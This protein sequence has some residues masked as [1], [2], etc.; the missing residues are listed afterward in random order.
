MKPS[1][2]QIR[3][4]EFQ[5][6]G[7]KRAAALEL[8]HGFVAIYEI[9]AR[10]QCPSCRSFNIPVIIKDG[11]KV[12]GIHRRFGTAIDCEGAFRPFQRAGTSGQRETENVPEPKS[13]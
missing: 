5:I 3:E 9:I 10:E 6:V 11:E 2:K 8:H 12:M 13:D 1:W 7:Q 4:G